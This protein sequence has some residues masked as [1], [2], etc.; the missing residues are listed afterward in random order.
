MFKNRRCNIRAGSRVG[1]LCHFFR[2]C[3]LGFRVWFFF[4]LVGFR[5]WGVG[6]VGF[7]VW[8]LGF[9]V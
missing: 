9:R 7:G 5:V 6:P 2:V 3:V 8:G 4:L 1:P